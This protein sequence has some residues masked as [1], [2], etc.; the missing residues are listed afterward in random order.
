MVTRFL[1][2]V[3]LRLQ[4]RESRQNFGAEMLTVFDQA[5]AASRKQGLW[6][7][8]RFCLRE[9]GGLLSPGNGAG[10]GTGWRW[11]AAGAGLGLLVGLAMTQVF[12]EVYTS[13]AMLRAVPS[14][15]P[16]RLAP[17]VQPITID[18]LRLEIMHVVLS[19]NTLTNVI[20]SYDL[21][22]SERARMPMEDVI[23]LMQRQV[24]FEPRAHETLAVSFEYPDPAKAQL[25]ARDLMTR[26]IDESTRGRGTRTA[27]VVEFLRSQAE[28]AAQSWESLLPAVKAANPASPS[29]ERLLLDRDLARRRYETLRNNLADAEMRAEMDRRHQGPILEVLD[30]PSL[31]ERP[32]LPHWMLVV[33]SML[34]GLIAGIL[35]GWLRAVRWRAASL[36]AR[37]VGVI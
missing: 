20:Q 18:T 26:L 7:Y 2:R 28:R 23:I 12:P 8:C 3:L 10:S 31:P 29:Y 4:S 25:V 16:A 11:P 34:V 32:A 19:R 24:K 33:A 30:L 21:Y 9:L 1:Y 17:D 35:F 14:D 13:R 22:R 36:R 6:S 27:L 37:P 5:S 15:I